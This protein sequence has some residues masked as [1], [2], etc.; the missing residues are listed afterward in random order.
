[1][2]RYTAIGANLWFGRIPGT[3]RNGTDVMCSYWIDEE[4]RRIRCDSIATLSRPNLS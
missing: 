3:F 1:M 2:R 4:M